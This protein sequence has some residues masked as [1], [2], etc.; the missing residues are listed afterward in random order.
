MACRTGRVQ[1]NK[2]GDIIKDVRRTAARSGA[3]SYA[4]RRLDA[5]SGGG[6]RAEATTS[7]KIVL[8]RGTVDEDGHYCF[9]VAL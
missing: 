4:V 7:H 2:A 3:A 5:A 9:A 8:W 1:E 6:G